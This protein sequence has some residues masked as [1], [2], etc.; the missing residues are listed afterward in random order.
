MFIWGGKKTFNWSNQDL[1]PL[2]KYIQSGA[3][4]CVSTMGSV[5]D[6][7]NLPPPTLCTSWR[8]W[9]S[10]LQDQLNGSNLSSVFT[11]RYFTCCIRLPNVSR[12]VLCETLWR[13]PSVSSVIFCISLLPRCWHFPS[14]MVYRHFHPY[15]S[16]SVL[17]TETRQVWIDVFTSETKSLINVS[18]GYFCCEY[19]IT[20][21][22]IGLNVLF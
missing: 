2:L 19:Y 9:H 7:G 12:V 14:M 11:F 8:G 13:I 20:G 4:A 5:R 3:V 6:V 21:S 22:C 16:E 18:I 17:Q 15:S 10:L 1:F